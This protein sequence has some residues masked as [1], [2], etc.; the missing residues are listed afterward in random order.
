MKKISVLIMIPIILLALNMSVAEADP[1]VVRVLTQ[2][3][4]AQPSLVQKFK[5]E[6]GIKVE[7]TIS[8][9]EEIISKLR[10]TRGGE[11]DLVLP[12]VDRYPR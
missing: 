2:G 9:N 5:D 11:Y 1:S 8:N 12:S 3:S 6:T 10:A 4:Y 7:M